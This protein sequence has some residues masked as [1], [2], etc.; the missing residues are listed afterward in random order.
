MEFRLIYRGRLPALSSGRGGTRRE[1]KHAIRK[2]LHRQLKQ[3]WQDNSFLRQRGSARIHIEEAG[4]PVID[5]SRLEMI[6]S[7][8]PKRNFRFVP[9]VNYHDG[10]ACSLDILFLRRDNPGALIKSGGDIDNRIAVLFDALRMP[11]DE[12]EI[13]GYEPEGTEQPFFCLLEDDLLINNVNIVTD[14]LLLPQEVDE[15][16]HDVVLLIHIK[17]VITDADKAYIE[18]Y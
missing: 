4:K 18:F 17:T 14:R 7:H 6:A 11:K 8:Y 5:C 1:D 15:G 16:I 2:E 9:L 10:I 3:L 13:A 12:Q